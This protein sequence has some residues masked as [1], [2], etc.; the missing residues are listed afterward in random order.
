MRR[1][2][3]YLDVGYDE[4]NELQR[5]GSRCDQALRGPTADPGI[6]GPYKSVDFRMALRGVTLHGG[7]YVRDIST[8]CSRRSASSSRNSKA[9]RTQHQRDRLLVLSRAVSVLARQ[10]DEAG[11][12]ARG[13]AS[14]A[15]PGAGH[16]F[17]EG[18]NQDQ[19]GRPLFEDVYVA[20]AANFA[21]NPLSKDPHHPYSWVL[22]NLYVSKATFNGLSVAVGGAE[23]LLDFPEALPVRAWGLSLSDY[24]PEAEA[25]NLK[26]NDV[27]AAGTYSDKT[28]DKKSGQPQSTAVRF[29]VDTTVDGKPR[30]KQPPALDLRYD[31]AENSVATQVN[32]RSATIQSLAI[33]SPTLKI[34]SAKDSRAVQLDDVSANVK[35]TFGKEAEGDQPAVPRCWTSTTCTSGS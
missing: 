11:I 10:A 14:A 12:A 30:V 19:A 1:D 7:N 23:P 6:R 29:G 13:A 35:V 25:I 18:S 8:A 20:G 26:I 33:D 24:N 15:G 21:K 5:R 17:R 31:P 22:K 9:S 16:R 32:L 3:D 4:D 27:Q 28:P 34:T 2:L